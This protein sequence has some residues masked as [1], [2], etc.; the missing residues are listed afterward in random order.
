MIFIILT[1]IQKSI[2]TRLTHIGEITKFKKSI[3][4]RLLRVKMLEGTKSMIIQKNKEDKIINHG[5][6][7]Q[8]MEIIDR[9]IFQVTKEHFMNLRPIDNGE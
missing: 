2:I 8:A 7:L 9:N 5:K 6:V 4:Q 3:A 1:K